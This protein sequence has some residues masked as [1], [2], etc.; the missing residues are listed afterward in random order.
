MYRVKAFHFIANPTFLPAILSLPFVNLS[1]QSSVL[2]FPTCDFAI[3]NGLY[4]LVFK[5][6]AWIS[7]ASKRR[8]S[9]WKVSNKRPGYNASDSDSEDDRE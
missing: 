6:S 4:K 3:L 1:A 5:G 7:R 8:A 9:V 2:Y